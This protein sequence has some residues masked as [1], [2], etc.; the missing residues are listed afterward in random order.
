MYSK[1]KMS[2]TVVK[3]R[4]LAAHGDQLGHPARYR[5]AEMHDLDCQ[6]PIR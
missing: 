1:S 2:N 4:V 6:Q 3:L 5:Y